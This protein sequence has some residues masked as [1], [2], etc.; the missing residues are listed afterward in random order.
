MNY[1]L[2]LNRAGNALMTCLQFSLTNSEHVYFIDG[3]DGSFAM[4]ARQLKKKIAE[5]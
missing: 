1:D 5:D 2:G 4:A 3:D